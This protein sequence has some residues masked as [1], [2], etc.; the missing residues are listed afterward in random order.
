MSLF[1]LFKRKKSSEEAKKKQKKD[2]RWF[3]P[4]KGKVYPLTLPEYYRTTLYRYF[5]NI[6]SLILKKLRWS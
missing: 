2:S 3:C 5:P 1:D 6:P 4:M